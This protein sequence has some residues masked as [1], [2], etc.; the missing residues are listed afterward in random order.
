[1]KLYIF[2]F[3]KQTTSWVMTDYHFVI[4]IQKLVGH[5]ER[6]YEEYC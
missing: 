6:E 3:T 2:I 4:Q 5:I 1:M